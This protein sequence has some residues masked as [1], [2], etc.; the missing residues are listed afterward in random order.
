MKIKPFRYT[1]KKD[2]ETKDYLVLVLEEN[3]K[4]IEGLDLSKLDEKEITN[5][6]ST[7]IELEA[8]KLQW[9]QEAKV[10]GIDYDEY[11]KDK[12]TEW[13]GEKMSPHFKKAYRKFLKENIEPLFSGITDKN[14]PEYIQEL[15]ADNSYEE[16]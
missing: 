4:Y 10:L 13:Y 1:K 3:E 6:T 5:A 14:I 8:L 9:R 2:G 15:N 11:V 12:N 16:K 7:Q